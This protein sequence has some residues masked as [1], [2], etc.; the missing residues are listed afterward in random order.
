MGALSINIMGIVQPETLTTFKN[1]F[2]VGT[3]TIKSGYEWFLGGLVFTIV[4]CT[5]CLYISICNCATMKNLEQYNQYKKKK[6]QEKNQR[7]QSI[8]PLI[9]RLERNDLTNQNQSSSINSSHNS[10][11]INNRKVS[12]LKPMNQLQEHNSDSHTS[13]D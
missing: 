5:P 1:E 11:N 10:G 2:T 6:K 4:C 9:E 7:K 12:S 13:E 8:K 3:L